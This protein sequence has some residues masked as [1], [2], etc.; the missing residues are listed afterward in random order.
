MLIRVPRAT[1]LIIYKMLAARPR[2][3]QDVEELVSLGLVI[4]NDRI[5]RVLG[6]FDVD[7]GLDRANQWRRVIER[8]GDL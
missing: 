7:L 5:E 8:C 6:E 1:D 2:D 3:I 4:D